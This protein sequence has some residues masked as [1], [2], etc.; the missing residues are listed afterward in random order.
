MRTLG[1][2][3]SSPP[4]SPGTRRRAGFIGPG[5][6]VPGVDVDDGVGVDVTV[7]CGGAGRDVGTAV[8]A[9]TANTMIRVA[10]ARLSRVRVL[11]FIVFLPSLE[12]VSELLTV[13]SKT[14][15]WAAASDTRILG[16]CQ[17]IG[18]MGRVC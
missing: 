3:C 1:V 6:A 18:L 13:R 9:A 5:P 8:S 4:P 7:T 11:K 2:E 10:A 15:G 17:H 14:G 16:P 12:V